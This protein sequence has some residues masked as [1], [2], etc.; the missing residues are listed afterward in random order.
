MGRTVTSI[1]EELKEEGILAEAQSP[2]AIKME[3]ERKLRGI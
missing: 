1:D 2:L 3:Q